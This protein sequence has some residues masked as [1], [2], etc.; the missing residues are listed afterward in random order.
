MRG[1]KDIA[2]RDIRYSPGR[3]S[4]WPLARQ[5]GAAPAVGSVAIPGDI[6]IAK[7]QRALGGVPRHP[8]IR[9][10]IEDNQPARDRRRSPL[11]SPRR[12]SRPVGR[13]FAIAG[14]GQPDAAG[15][16]EARFVAPEGAGWK[17]RGLGGRGS[18]S[19]NT[20]SWRAR[21]PPLPRSK[22][23]SRRPAYPAPA[24]DNRRFDTPRAQA[25]LPR[26]RR[27]RANISAST[28]LAHTAIMATSSPP[29]R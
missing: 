12:N 16:I 8:A 15:N 25:R 28:T 17:I 13:Q 18:T 20:P 27:R 21:S 24:L 5:T 9:Q 10:A 14:I 2:F 19:T 23:P 7:R 26:A 29:P 11:N 3:G 6:R 4:G 22:E 1:A